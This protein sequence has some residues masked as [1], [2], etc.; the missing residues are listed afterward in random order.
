VAACLAAPAGAAD[1]QGEPLPPAPESGIHAPLDGLL[2]AFVKDGVVDYGCLQAH[3]AQLGTY[4]QVLARIDPSALS[5]DS[6]LAL[7]INAYNA[8]T[9]KLI[10]SRYPALASIKEIPRRWEREEW[11]VG[12]R[13]YSLDAIEHEILRREFHE[14]RIHFAIVCASK[15]CPDLAAEAYLAARLDEQLDRAARGLLADSRKGARV[16]REKGLLGDLHNKL[17]LSA[18]FKWFREDFERGGSLVDFVKG[19][20][21]AD[22]RTF[23]EVA[24]GDL[25]I[26]FM[27]YDWTLNGR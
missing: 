7:W 26:D 21:P 24:G 11:T 3:E 22:A 23:V 15:S 6:R 2:R 9:L 19:Y 25:A 5:R 16:A 27:D 13:R 14:P 4:L 20:L 12:G 10:L 18:I 8:F 1:C 17:Y